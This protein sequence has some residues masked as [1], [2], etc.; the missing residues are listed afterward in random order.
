MATAWHLP[1]ADL[2]GR[3]DA[4][5]YAP[6]YIRLEQ[7]LRA[8]T[9][10]VVSLGSHLNRV[11]KGAFYLLAS[12]Y[13]TS[14]V[15][16]IRVTQIA[17][18]LVDLRDTV[19]ISA[20]AHASQCKTAVAPGYLLF[21][22]GGMYR[23]SAVVPPSVTDA[24]ISQDLIA[25]E[26]CQALDSHYALAVIQSKY[27][28][29]QLVRWEQG[30]AQPHLSNEGVKEFLIPLPHSSAVQ[31]YIGDKVRQGE[32]LRERARRLD[33]EASAFFQLPEWTHPRA[34]VR[35]SFR[36]GRASMLSD[37][38]DAPF[39][40]TAHFDLERLLRQRGAVPMGA[41]AGQITTR[42]TKSD[43]RLSYIE[44]GD[45]DIA[46]GVVRPTA[47]SRSDAPASA[48]VVVAANDVLVATVRPTRKNVGLVPA[49]IDLAPVVA[50]A[51][52]AVLR[53]D[54]AEAA[55]F[56]HAFL[57][58]D[59]ATQQLVRWNS[60][61][62]YPTIE[63]EVATCVL[64]PRYDGIVVERLGRRWLAKFEAIYGAQ[65]LIDAS[66][67]LVEHLID[68]RTTEADLV[69][70][71][72]AL[73]AGDRSADREILKGLRQSDAPDAKPVITD[74]DAL[75]ALLDGS[76]GQEA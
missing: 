12:E 59:A 50:S 38:L 13:T 64:A 53:F 58:S 63:P 49:A 57:R 76:E 22:K 25:A 54:T 61:T 35:R 71:Q 31:R 1:S 60:G 27:G 36:A 40:D 32:R 45:V 47:M 55:A 4:G 65:R 51:A 18:G 46:S 20:T 42:W 11:F 73:E 33:A 68:G 37:R 69:A 21:A 24:N 34:G 16:F 29:P 23:H 3:L 43:A 56:Y 19:F 5:F 8:S 66:K 62:T 67:L 17:S 7:Q 9:L 70:A 39:Y 52:F 44:I 72:K 14:G 10:R 26:P 75:Y 41:I 30:N 48:Q 6:E 15:P 28:R 2:S 74:V